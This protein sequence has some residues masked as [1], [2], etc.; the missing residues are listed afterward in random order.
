MLSDCVN[1]MTPFPNTSFMLPDTILLHFM[2]CCILLDDAVQEMASL[3]LTEYTATDWVKGF[4]GQ[5]WYTLQLLS[6]S[7]L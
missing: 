6:F 5:E 3:C 2:L 4:N 7:M 1:F